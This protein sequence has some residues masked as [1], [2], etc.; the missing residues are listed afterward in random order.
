MQRHIRD[1]YVQRAQKEGYRSRAA[2]KLLEIQAKDRC[3]KPGQ[4]IVD[5]GAAPGGWL[6]VSKD[7]VGHN[8]TLI[9][10]D[11]L[12]IQPL[13]GVQLIQGDFS[14]D[15]TLAQL[16]TL[17]QKRPVDLVISDMAPNVSG[18]TA[19]D[20]PRSMH[21]C[22]LALDFCCRYLTSGGGFICKVFQGE[23]FDDFMQDVKSRFNRVVTR[24]PK[25][26][27][28][29]SREVYMVASNYRA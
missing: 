28:P 26:S 3:I 6:Q 22:E 18:I 20:Q 7:I 23:G 4:T 25:A 16:E 13:P 19:V 10:L 21:L 8:G 5:L 29:K 2:Y 11:L 27:R 14:S 15:E 1:E 17:L 9:G 24:K 12:E